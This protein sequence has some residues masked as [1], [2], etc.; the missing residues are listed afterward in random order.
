MSTAHSEK[1]L[2]A[3]LL[4]GSGTALTS[5]GGALDVSSTL[6]GDVTSATHDNFNCNANLQISDTDLAFGQAAMVASLPVVIASDQSTLVVGDG[7]SSL[8]VDATALD[9]RALTNADV[10]RGELT[11]VPVVGS[12]GNLWSGATPGVRQLPLLLIANMSN[13]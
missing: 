4:D 8:T 11:V 5:T 2:Y 6:S 1:S 7:G 12:Q 13:V 9:I 3:R 10:V